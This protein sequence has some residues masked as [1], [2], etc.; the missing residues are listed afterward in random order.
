MGINHFTYIN[1]EKDKTKPVSSQFR[2]VIDFLGFDPTPA[3]ATLAERLAAKRRAMGMTF[4]Q[5]AVH[6]GWDPGTL[7][8]YL[9]GTWRMPAGRADALE[10]FL[11][12]LFPGEPP[13]S[14]GS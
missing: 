3:P 9:N 4:E 2:P 10:R 13:R 7:T 5:T 6:L 1:W 14:V 11:D 12:G 8:R